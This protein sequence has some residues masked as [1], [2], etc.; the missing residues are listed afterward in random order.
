MSSMHS[1]KLAMIGESTAA[2]A[3]ASSPF[4]RRSY[5]P[6]P[7]GT[8]APPSTQ[9]CRRWAHSALDSASLLSSALHSLTA[10][11]HNMPIGP[12]TDAV[13]VLAGGTP[14]RYTF[15]SFVRDSCK[16]EAA[17]TSCSHVCILEGVQA[18]QNSLLCLAAPSLL[19]VVVHLVDACRLC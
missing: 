18:T 19:H 10:H 7:Q 4:E 9:P 14:A 3:R 5:W 1:R 2:S 11:L 17:S 13:R 16:G 12:W 8:A 6:S 15:R